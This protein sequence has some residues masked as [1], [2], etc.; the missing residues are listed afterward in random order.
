MGGWSVGEKDMGYYHGWKA[1]LKLTQIF[2][3]IAL[4]P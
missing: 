2:T 1:I 3:S 4:K